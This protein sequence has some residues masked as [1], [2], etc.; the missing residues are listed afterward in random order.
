M[1]ACNCSF[2]AAGRNNSIEGVAWVA[3]KVLFVIVGDAA[4]GL[5]D[6]EPILD[7]FV[8]FI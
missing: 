7:M 1:A 3:C 5:S 6:C 8:Y 2:W 4:I